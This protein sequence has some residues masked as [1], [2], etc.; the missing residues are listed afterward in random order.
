MEIFK[1][2]HRITTTR[3]IMKW[4]WKM[5]Y[6]FPLF[7]FIMENSYK[8]LFPMAIVMYYQLPNVKL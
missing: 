6:N 5:L 1:G 7:F 4:N 2:V 8:I 3:D